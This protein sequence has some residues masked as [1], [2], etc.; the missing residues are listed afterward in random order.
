MDGTLIE[1]E[2]VAIGATNR[3]VYLT[4]AKYC[5]VA[6]SI[7]CILGFAIFHAAEIA[8]NQWLSEWSE[9]S[10]DRSQID[11]RLTIY[12]VFGIF[13]STYIFLIPM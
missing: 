2:S 12:G 6:M 1:E 9:V 4:Y 5:G 8:A 13:Q 3:S 11:F 10:S 7:S